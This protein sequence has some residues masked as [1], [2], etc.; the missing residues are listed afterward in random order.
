MGAHLGHGG[1]QP[2]WIMAALAHRLLLLAKGHDATETIAAIT[3]VMAVATA[4]TVSII[5]WRGKD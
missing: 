5:M 4:Y 2:G 1:R 3:Q